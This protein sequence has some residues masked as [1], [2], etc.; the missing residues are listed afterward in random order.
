MVKNSFRYYFAMSAAFLSCGLF[1]PVEATKDRSIAIKSANQSLEKI[2]LEKGRRITLSEGDKVPH[3]TLINQD[4]DWFSLDDLRGHPFVL[5]FIFTRCTVGEMCPASTQRMAKLQKAAA[6][7]NHDALRFVTITF[8][9]EFDTP[10]ILRNYAK[11]YAINLDNFDFLTYNNADFIDSLL[12]LFGVLTRQEND[13]ITHTNTT[14]LIDAA[15]RVA[16]KQNGPNWSAD[17]IL[18]AAESF[19]KLSNTP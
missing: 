19:S 14:Y 18:Q 7:T 6:G 11:A 5:N 1:L 3:F 15:G 4:G 9:P 12:H 2:I 17:K 16:L 8:D 13:T 10:E